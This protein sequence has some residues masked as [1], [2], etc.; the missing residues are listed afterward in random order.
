MRQYLIVVCVFSLVGAVCVFSLVGAG[1]RRKSAPGTAVT[2]GSRLERRYFVAQG[3]ARVFV[4]WFDSE[5][6]TPCEIGWASDGKRRCLP[7]RPYIRRYSTAGV[8]GGSI[9]YADEQCS[10]SVLSFS[11]LCGPPKYIKSGV[12]EDCKTLH[13]VFEIGERVDSADLYR[14]DASSGDCLPA[15]QP[16]EMVYHP[17]GDPVA[18][19][20]FVAFEQGGTHGGERLRRRVL[21]GEDG[22][23]GHAEI[24]D[25]ALEVECSP[26]QTTDGVMRCV[27]ETEVGVGIYGDDACQESLASSPAEPECVNT[28]YGMQIDMVDCELTA[29]VYELGSPVEPET[30]FTWD[31]IQE[32]CNPAAGVEGYLFWEHGPEVA[33]T[34]FA[35]L[36]EER[37]E[38]AG[39][40]KAMG[41]GT[42]DGFFIEEISFWDSEREEKCYPY[43]TADGQVRCVPQFEP[44]HDYY[45]DVQC[46]QTIALTTAL[47]RLCGEVPAYGA[48]YEEGC[49]GAVTLYALEEPSAATPL[50]EVR[51]NECRQAE[52]PEYYGTFYEVGAQIESSSFAPLELLSQTQ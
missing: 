3:G 22:S 32:Q 46:T 14:W 44:I 5:L 36:S 1:C 51:E 29:K 16:D 52:I 4:E 15:P 17:V 43:K 8:I 23:R 10:V 38:S 39:R 50:F 41:L 47:N 35:P 12:F 33:P 9:L 31:P 2:A 25:S 7:Q 20:T 45:L 40:L 11:K 48:R 6:D 49:P 21:H 19:E 24:L 42:A 27:P 26:W 18:P 13:T 37:P 34:S 30:I 28:S